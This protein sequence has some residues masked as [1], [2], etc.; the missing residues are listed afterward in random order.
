M[1]ILSIGGGE[2]TLH[3][4]FEEFSYKLAKIAEYFTITTNGQWTD[5]K[6]SDAILTSPYSQVDISIDAGGENIYEYSREQA[7]YERLIRNIEYLVERK[8]V[9]KSETLIVL[10][11]MI[12]P[13]QMKEYKSELKK[14]RKKVDLVLPQFIIKPDISDY[15]EDVYI[16]VY[17][18]NMSTPRCT[19][20]FKELA[21]RW[22]GDIPV[23][24]YADNRFSEQLI[25]GNIINSN[26]DTIWNSELLKRLREAHKKKEYD[27][28]FF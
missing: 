22:N 25:L 1:E 21:I 8:K 26:I 2:P 24:T 4:K 9:Y 20:P 28:I 19:L 13:S 5:H 6:I 15:T 10:R 14:W 17:S 12:R 27:D 7:S 11:L 18:I 23:C 16:S 3:P